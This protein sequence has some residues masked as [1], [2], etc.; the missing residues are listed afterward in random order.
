MTEVAK[1]ILVVGSLNMDL[2]VTVD[3]F[4]I[5]GETIF[6]KT[7]ATFPGGKGANQAVAAA[8]LGAHVTMVG[9]VGED[10]FGETLLTSLQE[11]GVS[12]SYIS[13][14]NT[15]TGT[16]LITVEENGANSIIVV[17]GANQHCSREKIDEALGGFASPGI[18]LLQHEIPA[19]VVE[20]A[21]KRAKEEKWTIILN[22]APARFVSEEILSMVDIVIPNE[23][24]IMV[25]TGRKVDSL[26]ETAE[27]GQ[28]LLERGASTV[29]ITLGDKGALCCMA[30]ENYHIPSYKVKAIDTTAAGDSYVGALATALAE[31]KTML[32][33]AKFA[34]A[35]AALSVTRVGAQPALP[36]KDEVAHFIAKQGEES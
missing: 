25:L 35:A 23:T 3:R 34:A 10:A 36:W 33:S 19:E 18:L 29:M 22:P 5:K 17:P 31:G 32:D 30:Q 27:A 8:K 13:K 28:V 4:P 24:E 9:A 12:T 26:E 11:S 20:Y 21:V 15:S 2:V 7:F 14:V 16:A 1:P 6:G